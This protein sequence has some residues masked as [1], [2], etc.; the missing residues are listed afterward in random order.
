MTSPDSISYL[1]AFVAGLLT[2]LSPCLLPLIPSFIAYITG[3]SFSDLADVEKASEV[4]R[5]TVAH[6]LL[7]ILGFSIV[8]IALGLTATFIGKALFQYQK[9]IRIAGGILIMIFGLYLTGLLKL[10]FLVK[11][12]RLDI[13]VKGATYA[14]SFLI[15]VTFAAAWTPCAGPIL[16]SILVLAGTKTSVAEGAKLLTV[17]SMGVAIPF[18]ITALVINS[19]LSYFNRLKKMIGAINVAAGILLIVVGFLVATNYLSVITQMLLG[20]FTK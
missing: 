9:F 4:R 5:K 16:G 14:G 7:F 17:Y 12:R 19:F 15:G 2:F 1:V 3:I 18:F 8:F 10:D 13:K 11:E 20:G 6:A